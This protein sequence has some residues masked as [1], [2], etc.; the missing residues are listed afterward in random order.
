VGAVLCDVLALHDPQVEFDI[1]AVGGKGEREHGSGRQQLSPVGRELLDGEHKQVTVLCGALAEAAPLAARLGPEAMYHLM[2]AVL[3]LVQDTVQRY[4]GI[5]LQVSGEGFLALFGAPVAQEDHARRA[6]LAACEL[7]QRLHAPDALREQPHSVAVRLGLH[8]GPVVIGPLVHDPQLPY[9][10]VGNTLYVATRLQQQAAPATIL[11]SAATYRLIQD[12]VQGETWAAGTSDAAAIPVAGYMVHG[13]LRRRAGVPRRSAQPLSRFVGRARELAL[14]HE[15]LALAA[16]RQG[17][18]VGLVGEPGMGKSRLLAEFAHS[19]GGQAVT[20]CEG[21]CLAYGS[22][23]PY[24][25]VR[26]LPRQLWDLPDT[27]A[28][29]AIT[30]TIQQQLHAAGIVSDNG[31]P[32]FLQFLDVPGEAAALADISPQ[33]RRAQT[34]AL[35]RQIILHASQRRPLVL[36]VENLHWSDPTSEEWLTALAAQLGGTAILLLATY[37]PGYRLPWLAHSWATQVA[38]PPLNPHDS[39]AVVQTVPQAA[40]LSAHQHQAIVTQAAGN[41]FFLEELTWAAVESDPHARTR[42]LPDT[43]QAVLAARLDHLPLE[44]KRLVQIAAVIGPEVPMPLLERVVGLAEDVLRRS[45]A[46]LQGAELLY[47]M[48]LFPDPVYTFKHALTHEVAYNSLLLEQ[49]RVLHARIVEAFEALAPDRLDEQVERLAHHALRGEVWDKAFAYCRQAGAKAYAGSA[50]REAVGYWEQALEALAHLPAN[51]TTTEQ[52]V[53]VRCDLAVALQPLGQY[54]QGLPHLREA[55]TLAAGLADHHR[56]G[57]IYRCIAGTFRMLQDYEPAL[58]YCQRA[59]AMATALGDVD[60]QMQVNH[61]MGM[62]SFDLGDYRQAMAY[63]QQILTAVQGEQC[64]PSSGSISV[65]FQA[66]VWMSRCLGELGEFASALAYGTEALQIAE[67]SGRLIERLAF[68]SRVGPLQVRQGTLHTAIPLLERAVVLSQEVDM[69]NYYHLAAPWLGL[70]YALAG[71]AT[72]ARAVLEQLGGK[73]D[74]LIRALACGEAYLLVGD[75]EEA[76]RLAQQVLTD[77]R[78]NKGRGWEGW[79]LWLLGDIAMHRDPPD[80]ALADGYYR[81]ALTLADALGLRPLQEHCYRGLGTLYAETGQKET[82]HAALAAAIALY[83]AM[84]MTF[85]LPQAEAIRAQVA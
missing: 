51:R 69:P 29:D 71:R 72:D 5:L 47:E 52:A 70:A 36:A 61:A 54:A 57:R 24:L 68:Y 18:A 6:V 44:T 27:A 75:V 46:H 12:E 30:A 2:R 26:D 64:E 21:H 49:R 13:L 62:I 85:W 53:D 35:L 81:Q 74:T 56:L 8:T 15:R 40:Q 77:A 20:Y 67:A 10:A 45:L 41:P 65:A 1:E 48:Q 73:T 80:L 32:L 9:T 84:D 78:H 58:A 23:T 43:V 25:P 83:R 60:I 33:E 34:F 82:A 76:H 37:R 16:S 63:V 14:L 11:V 55:E 17:Q 66:R 39:L 28:L 59:H 42:P 3:A 7:R 19:L 79:A 22:A 31:V 4:D 38:L 50:Y